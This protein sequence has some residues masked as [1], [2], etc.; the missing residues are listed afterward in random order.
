M[1]SRV[2][3]V[4]IN[5]GLNTAFK[6]PT[7]CKPINFKLYDDEFQSHLLTVP[8]PKSLLGRERVKRS[9][10]CHAAAHSSTYPK[11]PCIGVAHPN[12][13]TVAMR[14]S[15]VP[16]EPAIHACSTS[17]CSR[18]SG[19]TGTLHPPGASADPLA[20]LV[21]SFCASRSCPAIARSYADARR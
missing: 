21:G 16:N 6:R 13:G 11:R 4:R 14:T 20:P 17:K 15:N 8:N 19:G 18:T 2:S 1:R 5:K 12:L 3:F 9:P 7:T 10:A